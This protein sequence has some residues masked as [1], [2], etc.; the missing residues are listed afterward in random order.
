MKKVILT[1]G[2]PGSTK[3]TWTREMML[4]HPNTY[5]NVCKDDLRAMIDFGW[6]NGKKT[7]NFILK[8][9]NSIILTALEDGKHV[10]VSDTNLHPKHEEE[11]RELVKGKAQV[12]IK[13]FT[14]VSIDD[15]IKNDLKREN[16]VGEK[17]IRDM[18]DKF[19]KPEPVDVL[20]PE[21]DPSL[22]DCIICDLDG[23]LALGMHHRG[24]YDWMKVGDDIIDPAVEKIVR[25]FYDDD[26]YTVIFLT[27]RDGCCAKET[28]EWLERHGFPTNIPDSCNFNSF[29]YHRVAGDCRKDSIV[30]RE[31]YEQYIKGRYNVLFVLDDRSS[32]VQMW[33]NELGLKTLQVAEGNF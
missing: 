1:K 23:C 32:V 21:R 33:R 16:S 13:D 6:W 22:P 9:R 27:G 20:P 14:H 31:L 15:C 24:P 12:E 5:K 11:I 17:V 10:I 8:V 7:E 26:D 19:L 2:L 18:Y 30:K 25:K 3:S 28:G 29:L 4:S